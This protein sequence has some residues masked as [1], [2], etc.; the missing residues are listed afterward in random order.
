VR[1][2]LQRALRGC[3]FMV[4]ASGCAIHTPE[5]ATRRLVHDLHHGIPQSGL[6]AF[7]I[8]Q[9]DLHLSE[10]PAKSTDVYNKTAGWVNAGRSIGLVS[11][12][13]LR[14]PPGRFDLMLTWAPRRP[15]QAGLLTSLLGPPSGISY[16]G[17]RA[18]VIGGGVL[19]DRV[20][21]LLYSSPG[22]VGD[23]LDL[24]EAGDLPRMPDPEPVD[25]YLQQL[26][27]SGTAERSEIGG[28][29]SQEFCLEVELNPC[30]T[31]YRFTAEGKPRLL[32]LEIKIDN[33]PS[34]AA[35]VFMRL[36]EAMG[37]PLPEHGLQAIFS[38]PSAVP[39]GSASF[40]VDGNFAFARFHSGPKE[41]VFIWRRV[42]SPQSWCKH[43][44]PDL[45]R[46]KAEPGV[47]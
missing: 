29:K 33:P 12:E 45:T 30:V 22:Y 10:R 14:D 21:Y 35:S 23:P 43:F 32:G 47:N 28:M 7:T 25:Q 42:E 13:V 5:G 39:D 9:S 1:I 40:A 38:S 8:V 19:E 3:C 24:V 37:I 26:E 16:S 36:F 34:D 11:S 20:A 2:D 17:D 46:C 31:R 27:K 15:L 4:F 6:S 18:W 44:R 41:S